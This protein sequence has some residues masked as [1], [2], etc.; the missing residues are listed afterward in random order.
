MILMPS[1]KLKALII[2]YFLLALLTIQLTAHVPFAFAEPSC[3]ELVKQL[4]N[5][6]ENIATNGGM[7][8]YFE[9]SSLLRKHSVEAIQLDSRINKIFFTLIYL[10]ETQNGIPLNDLAIYI[11]RNLNEKSEDVFKAELLVLG[12]TSQEIDNWFNFLKYAQNHKF[13][14]LEISTIRNTIK[15]SAFFI[16]SYVKLAE[17]ITRVASPDLLLNQI[18]ALVINIDHFF[19]NAPYIIQALEE[20]SHVPYWDINESSGGS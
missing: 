8:G 10:C 4:E 16:K 20:I 13:R 19:S 6:T 1:H 11:S 12:K 5:K 14:T 15:E 3:L 17:N 7:W 9:K 18:R 2:K